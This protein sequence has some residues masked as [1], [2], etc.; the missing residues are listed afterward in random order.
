MRCSDNFD[1]GD[2]AIRDTNVLITRISPAADV[3]SEM[4]RSTPF[5]SLIAATTPFGID[6]MSK[7]VVT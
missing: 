2:P 4:T 5:E 1:L 6:V 3:S 7:V